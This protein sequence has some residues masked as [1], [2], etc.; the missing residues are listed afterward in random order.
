MLRDVVAA[1][2]E[3]KDRVDLTSHLTYFQYDH[4]SL[5]CDGLSPIPPANLA[6]VKVVDTSVD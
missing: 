4:M 3:Y 6:V 5:S 1:L 2:V